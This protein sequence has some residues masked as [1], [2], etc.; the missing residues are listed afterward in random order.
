MSVNALKM[1]ETVVKWEVYNHVTFIHYLFFHIMCK[2]FM[3]ILKSE[4]L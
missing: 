1:K 3:D 2:Y 4:I